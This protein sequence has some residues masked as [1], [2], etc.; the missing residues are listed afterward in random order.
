[1]T[2][3]QV[4][5]PSIPPAALQAPPFLVPTIHIVSFAS[6]TVVFVSIFFSFKLT[7]LFTFSALKKKRD[8]WVIVFK[9]LTKMILRFIEY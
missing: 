6:V 8:D 4:S 3:S 5:A 7:P 9:F 2:N 1:M